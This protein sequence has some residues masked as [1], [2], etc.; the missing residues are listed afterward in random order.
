MNPLDCYKQ[1][2]A[3][4]LH[5]YSKSYDY[6]K[7]TGKVRASNESFYKRRDKYR[8]DHLCRQYN[9]KNI[10]QFFVANFSS[11]DKYGGLHT[12]ESDQVYQDWRKRT[13]RLRYQFK[14]DISKLL[15]MSD[16]DQLFM[17]EDGQNPTILTMYYRGEISL[18]T[19]VI[20]N[21]ILNFFPQFDSQIEDDIMWP[22]TRNLCHKY[23]GFL[24][25]D[26]KV[27]REILKN[28]LDI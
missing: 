16:L 9:E 3:I 17:V 10:M 20:V 18:E 22:D 7:Y 23:I 15:E 28:K 19:F 24:D 6:F 26:V 25:V 27:F 13:Q 8:F 4:R 5:F 1:Y 11:G 12:E 14:S 21:Q 2:M